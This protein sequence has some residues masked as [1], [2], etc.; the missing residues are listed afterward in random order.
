MSSHS[1]PRPSRPAPRV[2]TWAVAVPAVLAIIALGVWFFG[3]TVSSYTA[4]IAL[5]SAWFAA[6]G[7]AIVIVSRRRRAWAA[8]LRT[9]FVAIAA[10]SAVGF[11]WTSIRDDKVDEAVVTGVAP[12]GAAVT[13][14]APSTPVNVEVARGAFRARAHAGSGTAAVVRLAG[15]GRKLTLTDFATDNGPDLRVYLVK[16][17]V[18]GDGDV[19]DPVDLG[20]LKGNIGNQQY[21]IPEGTD[22]AVY[23]TVVVWCRAFSVS[24]TQADLRVA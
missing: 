21:D 10:A 2:S 1:S 8:P 24:F 14:S 5:T 7:I 12:A 19:R 23:S 16:G 20:R 9:A 6:V 15:G 4:S 13:P 3:A 22:V 17:P 11:Y 18:T